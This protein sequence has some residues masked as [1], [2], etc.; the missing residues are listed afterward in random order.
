MSKNRKAKEKSILTVAGVGKIQYTFIFSASRSKTLFF[1]GL[2]GF[3]YSVQG[4]RLEAGVFDL[5]FTNFS[6]R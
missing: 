1:L 3:S 4:D 2:V 5:F 6:D